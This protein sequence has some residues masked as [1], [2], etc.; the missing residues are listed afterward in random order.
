MLRYSEVRDTIKDGDI[1]LFKGRGLLSSLIRFFT[2]S[3]F[4]HAG[5]AI[6]WHERL[7]VVEAVG[8]GVW[9]V[10]L[11]WRLATYKGLTYLLTTKDDELRKR[12]ITLDRVKLVAT[13]KTELGK[14][15]AKWLLVRVMRK[16]L[17]RMKG[18]HDP[19]R[20]PERLIC[21]QFVSRVYR[22]GNLDL[23]EDE[24]DEY[25]TPAHLATSGYL[26]NRGM[27]YT[28]MHGE[29]ARYAEL[30]TGLLRASK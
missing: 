8:R 9:A 20:P 27:L 7:M 11:S 22:E 10:P 21:S 17:F 18:G 4:T 29:A 30:E 24:P 5:I 28:D 15:Y 19:W 25:T 16:I 12:N 14:D 23:H 3:D 2:G 13:A 26:Q 6:W 1:V